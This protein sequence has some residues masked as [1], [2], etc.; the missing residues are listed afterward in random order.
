MN[1][2][3]SA[4]A[5]AVFSLPQAALCCAQEGE[6][7]GTEGPCPIPVGLLGALWALTENHTFSSWCPDSI[8]HVAGFVSPLHHFT[9]SICD[10][11]AHGLFISLLH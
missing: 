1:L 8:P 7:E 4:A 10:V 9:S 2:A 11:K 5:A 6:A 3:I